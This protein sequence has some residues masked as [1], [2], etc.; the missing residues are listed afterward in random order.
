MVA[1]PS[2]VN[3]SVFAWKT[4]TVGCNTSLT[5]DAA[6]TAALFL[7]KHSWCFD[8]GFYQYGHFA[9]HTAAPAR[10]VPTR[11]GK[12]ADGPVGRSSLAS[13]RTHKSSRARNCFPVGL[14]RLAHTDAHTALLL[15]TWTPDPGSRPNSHVSPYDAAFPGTL[16]VSNHRLFVQKNVITAISLAHQ[17]Y[18][19]KPGPQ[20]CHC[21]S[22]RHSTMFNV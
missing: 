12:T 21:A 15:E 4:V 19:H 9:D 5:S 22:I 6:A 10:P 7:P 14:N 20:N 13:R 2:G 3:V 18:M 16:P 1:G 8:Y 11:L 17:P